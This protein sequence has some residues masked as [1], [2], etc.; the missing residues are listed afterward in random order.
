MRAIANA[1]YGGGHST[2]TKGDVRAHGKHS[3]AVV[4]TVVGVRRNGRWEFWAQIR[5]AGKVVRNAAGEN[6]TGPEQI[7]AVVRL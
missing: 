4:A 3:D 6:A 7:R 1:A 5:E 2:M